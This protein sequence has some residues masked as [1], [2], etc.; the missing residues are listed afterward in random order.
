MNTLLPTA[1]PAFTVEPMGPGHQAA[2]LHFFD[3]D[4]FADNPRWASCYCQFPTAD[5]AS[6]S[7]KTRTVTDNRASACARVAAGEQSGVIALAEGR[8]VGWCNAGPWRSFTIMDEEPEPLADQL[9]AITCFVVTPAWRGRGVSQA[10]LQAACDQLKEQGFVAVD[11]WAKLGA[12]TPAD[13]HTG[14]LTLYQR[15]GF[16]A[17]REVDGGVVVRKP[18]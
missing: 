3:H 5:H 17:L 2:W 7:W 6:V 15:V 18:L 1:T 16:E 12:A 8:V 11:G 10:L 4:A 9:G 13:K 14:S